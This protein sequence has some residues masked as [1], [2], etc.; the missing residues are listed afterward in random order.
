MPAAKEAA[1]SSFL[2]ARIASHPAR[3]FTA[4]PKTA[5]GRPNAMTTAIVSLM[6]S[7]GKPFAPLSAEEI[8][9]RT[10]ALWR[11]THAC[12]RA[13]RLSSAGIESGGPADRERRRG[14]GQGRKRQG[15]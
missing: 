11:R 2:P 8:H 14:Q 7:H 10:S 6:R 13:Q 15:A 3:P 1:A 12:H 5:A 4:W 9:E